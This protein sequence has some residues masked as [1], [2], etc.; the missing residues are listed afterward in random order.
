MLNQPPP[1]DPTSCKQVAAPT[2]SG[3]LIGDAVGH[4][5]NFDQVAKGS[6][7]DGLREGEHQRCR[8]SKS[9][10]C[11]LSIARPTEVALSAEN[12]VGDETCD[13]TGKRN[14]ALC[15]A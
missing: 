7:S 10:V 4:F 14:D 8:N 13:E 3:H 5:M 12:M 15:R 9:E 6:S 11:L 1:A 2:T